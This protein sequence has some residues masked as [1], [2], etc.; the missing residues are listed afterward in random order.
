M[1]WQAVGWVWGRDTACLDPNTAFPRLSIWKGCVAEGIEGRCYGWLLF[2]VSS[3]TCSSPG[4]WLVLWCL[5]CVSACPLP[6][7]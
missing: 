6:Y 3:R 7:V 5:A 2:V 4:V 1:W